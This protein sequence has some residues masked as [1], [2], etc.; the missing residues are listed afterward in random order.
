MKMSEN[1]LAASKTPFSLP[2]VR[3]IKFEFSQADNCFFH[4]IERDLHIFCVWEKARH[5]QAAIT[6]LLKNNFRLLRSYEMVWPENKVAT[7]FGRLY[8]TLGYDINRKHETA[9]SGPFFCIVVEDPCPK[10]HYYQSVSGNLELCN[11][12]IV[13]AKKTVRSWVG[14]FLVHSTST[15]VEFIEQANLLFSTE[16]VSSLLCS[17]G[18]IH[19]DPMRESDLIG[20]N[21]WDDFESLFRHLNRTTDYVVLRNFESIAGQFSEDDLDV[22]CANPESFL[23]AANGMEAKQTRSA[24]QC[25]ILVRGQ[26]IPVDIRFVGDG[27]YDSVWQKEI[28]RESQMFEGYVRVPRVDHH[29]FS[30]LY[31]G[32][33]QKPKINDKYIS[34][35]QGLGSQIGMPTHLLEKVASRDSASD[36]MRG[37]LKANNYSYYTPLDRGVHINRRALTAL[38]PNYMTVY[39]KPLG[40]FIAMAAV[41][42]L[43]KWR[44]NH[45]HWNRETRSKLSTN[46]SGK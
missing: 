43:R 30:L 41:A 31:H 17:T 33:F 44:K 15:P 40:S 21:G 4:N 26:K 19:Q 8:K 42:L 7:N 45:I 34:R 13:E 3:D 11:T 10:Y 32:V 28:L 20:S 27:Y 25:T 46:T 6:D 23:A 24:A 38:W 36:I 18:Y 22:L 39:K 1:E 29:F 37:Y 35:L 2:S 16:E 14:G 12:N 5:M 9:G